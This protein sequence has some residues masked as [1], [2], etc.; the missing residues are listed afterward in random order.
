MVKKV[1]SPEQVISYDNYFAQYPEKILGKAYITTGRF[2]DQVTKYKG[3]LT[4]LDKISLARDY[5]VADMLSAHLSSAHNDVDIDTISGAA[6]LAVQKAIRKSKKERSVRDQAKRGELDLITFDEVDQLYNAHL[7]E[8]EKQVFVWYQRA[9]LGRPM[10]GGWEKYYTSDHYS[11]KAVPWEWMDKGLVFWYRDGYLPAFVYLSGNIAE[12]REQLAQER[13][14]FNDDFRR[15]ELVKRQEKALDDLWQRVLRKRR[16][17]DAEDMEDRLIIKPISTLAKEYKIK[18]LRDD[19]SLSAKQRR[20]GKIDYLD[21]LQTGYKKEL[22][23]AISLQEAFVLWLGA[24]SRNLDIR[25][26][27]NWRDIVELYLSA[28]RRGKDEDPALFLKNKSAAQQEG[29]RLFSDFLAKAISEEDQREIE[30]IWNER[31]N[32]DIP[33]DLNQ[34]PIGF[35]MA[36]H[37]NGME[38]DIRPEKREAIAFAQMRGAGCLAYGVGLG[39][40]WAS[41]F[42]V[43]QFLENGWASRPFFVLPNQVYKQFMAECAGILPQYARSDLDNLSAKYAEKVTQEE[44]LPEQSISFF[45][46]EGFKRIGI[47]TDEE[48]GFF[49][50]LVDILDQ[51]TDRKA[52]ADK[53]LERLKNKVDSIIGTAKRGTQFTINDLGLDMMVV[54][55]AHSAKKV[56]TTVKSEKETNLGKEKGIKRYD[57]SSGEPSAMGLKTFMVSQYVQRINPTG[58]VLLLTA[59]P[60]TNSPMEIFSMTALVGLNYLREIGL[61][62]LKDFFDQFVNTSNEL[63]FSAALEPVFKDVFTG[64]SNLIALQSIIRRF[65]LYKQST[66]NLKRPNKI[67]LPL[68]RKI[69]DGMLIEMGGQESIETVLSFNPV[70]REWM[71]DILAYAQE[72]VTNITA[73]CEKAKPDSAESGNGARLLRAA[74]MAR[75]IAFSPYLLKCDEDTQAPKSVADFI[76]SSAKLE[77]VVGCIKSVQEYHQKQGTPMSG[78]II[79]ANMGVDYFPLLRDYLIKELGLKPYEV[80]IIVSE[81][82]MQKIGFK[83]KRTVQNAFLGRRY[84][85]KTRDYEDIPHEYR[86]KVLIGSS[87]IREGINLQRYASVLYTLELP[88]NPTDVNQLEG[89]LW[90]QGNIHKNVRIVNPLMEDSMDIFMFQ[91]LEEKTARINAIWD[92]D[93]NE[94]TLDTRDFDPAELKY[95][96]IKDPLR[97]AQLEA[98]E[99]DLLIDDQLTTLNAQ[100]SKLEEVKSTLYFVESRRE[101]IIKAVEVFRDIPDQ[102]KE[103][104]NELRRQ[105]AYMLRATKLKDGTP[106]EEAKHKTKDY[107]RNPYKDSWINAYQGISTPYWYKDWKANVAALNQAIKEILEPKGLPADEAGITKA[108]EALETEK[109]KIEEQKKSLTSEERLKE[110]AKEIADKKA[111]EGI[112]AATV[113]QRVDQFAKLN[114]MLDELRVSERQESV[115]GETSDAPYRKGE[116]VVYDG[117]KAK[118]EKAIKGSNGKVYYQIRQ[119]SYV[120][121]VLRDELSP[122]S[123]AQKDRLKKTVSKASAK[124]RLLKAKK[125]KKLK[126]LQLAA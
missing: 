43:A 1:L 5:V 79:Y 93:G 16:T 11:K 56:F 119:K 64:F 81:S 38:M 44:R 48:A 29:I 109:E 96:L 30:R 63:V 52:G 84:N 18:K 45:T 24:N 106:L 47:D 113:E 59:T 69:V 100:I 54:D 89:R 62:N 42:I 107:Y 94:N 2:S 111:R 55:E 82:R 124:I 74:G 36:R 66:K 104:P 58:N 26:G 10:K 67:V 87:T 95:V 41:I 112:A 110:R 53:D 98:Q 108:V 15:R 99:Q 114:Y 72:K 117:K 65:F 32:S 51:Q 34:V 4:D 39:K 14:R 49:S 17:L 92:F 28:R 88:W 50:E 70:Q 120:E 21:Q 46:Y 33:I 123:Q 85:P 80:G 102:A 122:N 6:S 125:A 9:V 75:K 8:E 83:D 12:R 13:W 101:E 25:R 37:Y 23:F 20:N 27:L 116:T 19:V 103:D 91:K 86:C 68:R 7:S 61:L 77:F 22:D 40:T 118:I 105:V 60:F 31:Y 97:I 126:L 35:T 121:L 76:K 78:Q 71:E 57:I 90:R 115:V 73:V 3:D